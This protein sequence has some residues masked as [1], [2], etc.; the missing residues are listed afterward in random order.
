MKKN[1]RTKICILSNGLWRGGTDTFVVNLVRGLDKSKYDI[2]VI[3]SISD[4]WLAAREQEVIEYGAKV[5]RTFGITGKGIK[6]RLRH[7]FLL[8]K[9][10]K[11]ERPDIFQT[12]I[13]L[14]NGPN[15]FVAWLAGVPI[16]ICHSHNSMQEQEASGGRNLAIALYQGLM[17]WLCWNF[18]NRRAGCSEAALNFLFG[19]KWKNDKRAIVVNNG[20][21]IAHFRIDID[22][23][24]KRQEIGTNQKYNILTVGRISPQ[25]N[26]ILI[27]NIFV[28]LCKIRSDCDLIWVGIGEMEES[29]RTIFEEQKV[30]NLVHFLGTRNDVNELMES[31]DLF[32]FPSLFEGLGIVVIE[33]QAAGLPCLISNTIPTMVDCGGCEFHSLDDSPEQWAWYLNDILDGKKKFNIDEEKLNKYS[34]EHMV[35][36]MESLFE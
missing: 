31:S 12:N 17:R 14:F 3:L 23:K 9:I 19:E 2:T 35:E 6:G 27:A 28:E 4:E 11:R 21:D 24:K 20:I 13:D 30:L 8:F 29:I 36:Q 26:P 25:K 34:I 7:L 33:A 1:K 18:S 22:S 5:V 32:L 15:L 16:R 10:L